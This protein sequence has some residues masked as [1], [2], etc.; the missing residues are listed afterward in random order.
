VEGGGGEAREI[1]RLRHERRKN[2]RL[3][4]GRKSGERGLLRV[5]D[6]GKKWCQR[7]ESNPRDYYQSGFMRKSHDSRTKVRGN[8]TIP[9]HRC[10]RRD[11][12]GVK[13]AV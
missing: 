1:S 7:G 4:R 5:T 9:G 10:Q 11:E 12:S 6:V 8:N 3:G 13:M 2:T